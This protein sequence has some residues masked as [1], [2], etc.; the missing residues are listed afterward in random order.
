VL[1]VY[2]PDGRYREL[3]LELAA[4]TAVSSPMLKHENQGMN[5][6][7]LHQKGMEPVDGFEPTTYC[8]QDSCSTS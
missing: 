4:A 1:V 7:F 8:L 2:D 5:P 6:G 3:C